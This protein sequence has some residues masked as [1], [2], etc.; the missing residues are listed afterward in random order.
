MPWPDYYTLLGVTRA[1]SNKE[2]KA[3]YHRAVLRLHPDKKVAKG[4]DSIKRGTGPDKG[5]DDGAWDGDEG[6]G[7]ETDIGCIAEA[8][9]TLVDPE[10]RSIY[11][12]A[13]VADAAAARMGP[14]PAQ[15]ISL[16]EFV[17]EKR[18]D[19]WTYRCRCGGV[20]RIGETEMDSGVHLVAC[21][22]CSEVIWVGY[23]VVESV[24]G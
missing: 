11:D 16:E 21:E 5:I 19:I 13:A 20:Y 2:I 4:T 10:R 8:Y 22:G 23:E 15:V 1:A 24:E 6:G 7:G 9:R 18:G 14:R 12:A 3:A 17:E